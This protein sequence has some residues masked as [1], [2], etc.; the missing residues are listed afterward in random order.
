MPDILYKFI[1]KN[2]NNFR[3]KLTICFLVCALIPVLF[4]G[5]SSYLVASNIAKE[6][7]IDSVSLAGNQMT[8][9]MDNRMNQ[10]ENVADS[11]HFYL[12]TLYQ[13]PQEPLSSYMGQFDSVRNTITS[14][15]N[16][17]DLYHISV[18]L[19]TSQFISN[20]GIH[21]L[22]FDHLKDYG[23]T[24][25]DLT[26]LGVA[27]RWVYHSDVDFPYIISKGKTTKNILGCYRSFGASPGTLDF[28]YGIYLPQDEL[29]DML[30]SSYQNSQVNAYIINKDGSIIAGRDSKQ[31]GTSLSADTFGTYFS[32]VSDTA[33]S[34]NGKQVIIKPFHND[35]YLVTEIPD[36]YILA[37]TRLLANVIL[38]ALVVV[39][40][41]TLFSVMFI[42]R[43]LTKKLDR[44]TMAMGEIETNKSTESEKL[45]ELLPS[46][47]EDCDEIDRL[48][49]QFDDMLHTLGTSFNEILNLSVKEEKLNYHLLQSQI[50]PHFLYNMLAS[51]RTL[52]SLGK[53]DTADKMLTDLSR[54]YR[55]ILHKSAD[56]IPIRDELEIAT[57]YME[58][59]ALCRNDCFTWDINL[60]DGI[61]NFLIC[62]FT[63]QPILENSILHG[64]RGGSTSM[65]IHISVTYEEDTILISIFDN[66]IG[67]EPPKLKDIQKVL[68]EKIVKYDKHFGIGNIN[69]RIASSLQEYGSMEIDSTPGEGTVVRILIPQLLED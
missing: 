65:H 50:N 20:E 59:E 21:F 54:F 60:D 12:Y 66:G 30:N 49:V 11:V 39:I 68:K 62:K 46:N 32:A 55:S 41:V 16:A 2:K 23:L 45:R 7:T 3:T 14:L 10:I 37:N 17:F 53:L 36:R 31:T 26:N 43:G 22:S 51:I 34:Y 9:I 28:A 38:M 35:W 63:L 58:M 33:F 8:S 69:A 19:D 13:T 4:I 15:A 27:P 25:N 52:L 5:I 6:K 24:T 40:I 57:L 44:L 67:I 61:E 1:K 56:L 64:F 18:F 47:L 29:S 48:A 42:S